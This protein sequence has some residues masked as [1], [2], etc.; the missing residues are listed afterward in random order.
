MHVAER[1]VAGRDRFVDGAIAVVVD[2]VVGDLGGARPDVRVVVVAVALHRAGAVLVGVGVLGAAA[3]VGHGLA[4]DGAVG[5]AAALEDVAA[6]VGDGAAG[7]ERHTRGRYTH[8]RTTVV[9]ACP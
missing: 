7:A 2:A 5:A 9:G 3:A 8:R 1:V 4:A 6:A